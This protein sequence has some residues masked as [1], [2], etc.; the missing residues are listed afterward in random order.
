[1]LTVV[2]VVFAIAGAS[3]RAVAGRKHWF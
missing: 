2:G 1:M 3:G